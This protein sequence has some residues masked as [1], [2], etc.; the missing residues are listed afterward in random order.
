MK[1]IGNNIYL[2]NDDNY[3]YVEGEHIIIQDKDNKKAKIPH[4]LI[5]SVI[6][7]GNTTISSHLLRFCSKNNI[8]LS[9]VSHYGKMYGRFIGEFNRCVILRKK[10]YDMYDTEKAFLFSKNILLSK[11]INSKNLLI[12]S[13]KDI[14]DENKINCL[15]MA[16]E[17]I[18]NT[19]TSLLNAKTY[20]ELLGIEGSVAQIYFS[21]FDNMLKTEDESMLFKERSKRP[22]Q[23]FCNCLLSFLY[24]IF[25]ND[26]T[27][28]LETTGL[29]SYLGFNHKLHAGRQ[30]LSLDLLEEFRSS[31]IDK[32]VITIIN[33]KQITSKDFE[34][35]EKGI[36]LTDNGRKKLFGIWEE[37]KKTEILHKY[38]NKKIEIK[39]LP[40]IQS[41]LLAKYI[42]G[43]IEEYPPFVR[44][45]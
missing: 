13:A 39:L 37:Y 35:K 27:S 38:Y 40:Y 8:N 21:V 12:Q 29:D 45:F 6:I 5:E 31:I 14:T 32:F 16:S 20:Q 28:A 34:E 11:F 18:S 9:Y 33:R 42:R 30:S 25:A 22:P 2:L 7:F 10:Q 15:L 26:I 1:H 17:K 23:N 24:T 36:L 43:D 41:Q 4:L 3:V 44:F 19:K